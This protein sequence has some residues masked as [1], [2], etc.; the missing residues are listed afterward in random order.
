MYFVQSANA[1]TRGSLSAK[2]VSIYKDAAV[3]YWGSRGKLDGVPCQPKDVRVRHINFPENNKYFVAMALMEAAYPDG[4]SGD[5]I[6]PK[7]MYCTVS[8]NK[9]AR[10]DSRSACIT[11]IHEYGHLLGLDHVKNNPKNVMYDGFTYFE[12]EK[13]SRLFA[14]HMKLVLADSQCGRIK[15]GK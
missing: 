10:E 13:S 8:Y 5:V 3:E 2:K 9:K 12:G 15:T 7:D 1:A 4:I 14:R 6:I 11:F